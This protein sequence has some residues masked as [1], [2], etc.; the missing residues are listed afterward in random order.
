MKK[1]TPL[2]L[3][4]VAAN[5][6]HLLLFPILITNTPNAAI[7]SSSIWWVRTVFSSCFYLPKKSSPKKH[8]REFPFKIDTLTSWQTLS[9]FVS[10]HWRVG[11]SPPIALV[12]AAMHVSRCN[13]GAWKIKT[14][15]KKLKT[16]KT[17]TWNSLYLWL[18]GTD[19][20]LQPRQRET[21]Y[22]F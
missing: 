3:Q 15:P 14:W 18:E 22:Q 2:Y 5:S 10:A 1:V 20:W 7:S 11:C 13:L 4:Y 16:K 17:T 8:V 9:N 12:M 21:T 19:V 6:N